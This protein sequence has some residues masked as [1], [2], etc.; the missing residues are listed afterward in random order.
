MPLNTVYKILKLDRSNEL[1]NIRPGDEIKFS[2]L[3]DEINRIEIKKDVLNSIRVEIGKDISIEKIVKEVEKLKSI[4]M[5]EIQSSFYESG[6][7]ANMPDSII[8]DFAFIFGRDQDETDRA[9][10]PEDAGGGLVF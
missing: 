3:N 10:G 9:C 7:Q 8:M 2:F 4:S 6:L 1:R 5:G